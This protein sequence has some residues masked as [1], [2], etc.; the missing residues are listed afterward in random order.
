MN[1][2]GQISSLS[3]YLNVIL[4]LFH[5][6]IF[7]THLIPICSQLSLF[8]YCSFVTLLILVWIE[9]LFLCCKSPRPIKSYFQESRGNEQ[10]PKD[11]G[12]SLK[13]AGLRK[14][15]SFSYPFLPQ[16]HSLPLLPI[17]DQFKCTFH[18]SASFVLL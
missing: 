3:G 14:I 6:E 2:H 13:T 8:L 11:P 18:T 16:R 17:R 5:L 4:H 10:L 9:S 15:T 12:D 1:L 7:L